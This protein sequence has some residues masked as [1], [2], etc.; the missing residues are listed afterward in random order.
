MTTLLECPLHQLP[1]LSLQQLVGELLLLAPDA[2]DAD[3][4][5]MPLCAFLVRVYY[6][7]GLGHTRR[8]FS[9][10]QLHEA[11]ATWHILP[12]RLR[13]LSHCLVYPLCH[14]IGMRCVGQSI[15]MFEGSSVRVFLNTYFDPVGRTRPKGVRASNS[16]IP[17]R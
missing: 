12:Q 14:E 2:A 15:E 5:D 17:P 8:R 9:R 7:D 13:D 1:D 11:G 10:Q 4:P 3:A 16:S 6:P